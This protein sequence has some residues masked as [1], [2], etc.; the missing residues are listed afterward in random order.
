MSHTERQVSNAF[1]AIGS[2]VAW[3]LGM[4]EGQLE[5]TLTSAYGFSYHDNYGSPNYCHTA[6]GIS[7]YMGG[8]GR[9]YIM[10]TVEDSV[11]AWTLTD[12]QMEEA[13]R[14]EGIT[15]NPA[16]WDGN[17]IVAAMQYGSEAISTPEGVSI[18][19]LLRYRADQSG[20]CDAI[21]EALVAAVNG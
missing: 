13:R 9:A 12:D 4:N 16:V 3:Q 8:G 5:T 10:Q 17:D 6:D 19:D 15:A 7:F 1:T 11:M 14:R 18:Y 2:D 21:I 20:Q